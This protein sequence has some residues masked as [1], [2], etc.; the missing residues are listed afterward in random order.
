MGT[1]MRVLSKS[2]IMNTNMTGFYWFSKIFASLCFS[3]GSLS[4]GRVINKTIYFPT[5][6]SDYEVYYSK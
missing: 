3:E 1:H 2:Y 4:I 5:F 6:L